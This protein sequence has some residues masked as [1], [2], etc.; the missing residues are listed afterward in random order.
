MS[1]FI[2]PVGVLAELGTMMGGDSWPAVTE[3]EVSYC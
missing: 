2:A 1:A 3:L